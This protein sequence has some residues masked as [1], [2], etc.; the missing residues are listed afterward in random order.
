MR[1]VKF[2]GFSVQQDRFVYGDLI[3]K[4]GHIWITEENGSDLIADES[5]VGE[6]IGLYDVN[7]SEIY[8]GD[9]VKVKGSDCVYTVIF[10]TG[11]FKLYRP[12][13]TLFT[14]EKDDILEIV[15]N[16]HRKQTLVQPEW[17]TYPD[18]ATPVLGCWSLL[19]GRVTGEDFCKRCELH[20]ENTEQDEK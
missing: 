17:C 4:G 19:N 9:K 10:E 6:F 7:G 8:E 16:I 13:G 3:T 15:G 2:R 18:A 11:A 14:I 5:T 12:D 20:K 1:K